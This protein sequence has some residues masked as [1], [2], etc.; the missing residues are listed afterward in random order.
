MTKL[1]HCPN[2]ID[3]TVFCRKDTDITTLSSFSMAWGNDLVCLHWP[4]LHIEIPDFDRQVVA[5]H[6]IA[7]TVAELH[8]R[9]GRDDFRKERT[10][11]WILWLFKHWRKKKDASY[12]YT[13]TNDIFLDGYIQFNTATYADQPQHLNHRQSKR[14]TLIKA[15]VQWTSGKLGILATCE[16]SLMA[17]ALP[18]GIH[19]STRPKDAQSD[20]DLGNFEARLTF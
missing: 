9:N 19:G 2:I 10:I 14:M 12:Y 7:T 20:F 13:L 8:I 5:G 1:E 18:H 6:H 15:T 4:G 3:L 17:T 11:V 16:C